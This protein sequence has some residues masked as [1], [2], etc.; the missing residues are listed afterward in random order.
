MRTNELAAFKGDYSSYIVLNLFFS[1]KV[2]WFVI[3]H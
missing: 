1:V 2:I 3:S